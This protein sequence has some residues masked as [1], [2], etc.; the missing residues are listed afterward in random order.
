MEDCNTDT[1]V[2]HKLSPAYVQELLQVFEFTYVRKI[3]S[4][5][6]FHPSPVNDAFL[7]R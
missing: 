7:P 4:K 3:F 6:I 5:Y 2:F 1:D